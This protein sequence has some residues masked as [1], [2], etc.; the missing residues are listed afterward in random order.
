MEVI[1]LYVLNLFLLKGVSLEQ[2]GIRHN[3]NSTRSNLMIGKHTKLICQGF[4]GKQVRKTLL[5][6]PWKYLLTK[7]SLLTVFSCS[8]GML[9]EFKEQF[10]L[11]CHQTKT[12]II[13]QAS[14]N[15]CRHSN[16]PIKSWLVFVLPLNGGE[17]GTRVS[18]S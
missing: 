16:E 14:R 17:S 5:L 2:I 7:F 18:F 6:A 13:T 10:L 9:F 15:R 11:K 1:E 8:K 12:E 3:Y 4:T